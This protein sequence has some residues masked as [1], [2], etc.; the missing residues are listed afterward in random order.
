MRGGK[1]MRLVDCKRA[2]DSLESKLLPW[3]SFLCRETMSENTFFPLLSI[4]LACFNT[5][6]NV[7]A[8]TV[9]AVFR[10]DKPLLPVYFEKK[11]NNEFPRAWHPSLHFTPQKRI[12]NL[13]AFPVPHPVDFKCTKLWKC[14]LERADSYLVIHFSLILSLNSNECGIMV[15]VSAFQPC[16]KAIRISWKIH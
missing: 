7:R 14:P 6:K 11:I 10:L 13:H 1:K 12:R 15:T 3:V 8:Q 4:R 5:R 2:D 16:W 9:P